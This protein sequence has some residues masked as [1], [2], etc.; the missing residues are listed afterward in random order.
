MIHTRD[1]ASLFARAR[2]RAS[3]TR[4]VFYAYSDAGNWITFRRV[5]RRACERACV[6]S[7]GA[8]LNGC[9]CEHS[10]FGCPS[11][12]NPLKPMQ[13]HHFGQGHHSR[14]IAS[15]ITD[16]YSCGFCRVV[17]VLTCV[18]VFVF[19]SSVVSCLLSLYTFIYKYIRFLVCAATCDHP[20]NRANAHEW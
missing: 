2:A 11:A 19:F 7:I 17:R 15:I 4:I 6:H 16:L 3:L 14:E 18:W 12:V 5:C 10:I 1:L 20:Q 9:V 13:H 8:Q